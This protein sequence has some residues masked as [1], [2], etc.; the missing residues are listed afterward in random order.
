MHQVLRAHESWRLKGLKA[1][2]VL[3]NEHP[4]S[5]RNEMHEELAKIVETGPWGAWKNQP[6][7]IFVL[8]GEALGEA[9]RTLLLAAAKAILSGEK[10][11]LAQQLDQMEEEPP[12]PLETPFSDAPPARGAADETPEKI[13]VPPLLMDN[14]T[15]GFT[16]DGREYV[17]VL[18]G[19]KETPLPWSNILANPR[20][21][22]LVSASGTSYTWAENSRENRLTPF[23]ND[24]V[25]DATSE[26]L[27]LRDDETGAVFSATP[28]PL[29]RTGRSPRWVVRHTAGATRFT[30]AARGL[31]TEL[32]VFVAR[33]DPVKLSLLT[34]T[35]RSGRPRRLSLFSYAA[36]GLGP[37]RRGESYFVVTERTRQPDA[38]LARNPY[39]AEYA[40]HVAF[41]GASER[42]ASATGDRLEFF[43]RNGT[44]S[45]AAAFGSPKLKERF[46][47][48]LDPCAALQVS[49]D[50]APGETKRVVFSLGQGRD[51]GEAL[52]LAEKY[53]SASAAEE[54]L[55]A[56]T[57][58]WDETLGAVEVKTPDDSFDLL[59]N[60]WLLYQ[61]LAGRYWA[62]CGYYQASG[63]FGFRDQL[64]DS[65]A[66]L[67]VRP[68]LT[69]EHI[70]R[71]AARQFVEGDVQHW[72]HPP[73]GRGLRSRCSDDLLWLPYAVARYLDATGDTSIL[74]ERAPYLEAPPVPPGEKES[75]GLP[76]VSAESDTLLGHCLRAIDKGLTLGPHGL[77]LIGS[78]D[79]NDGYDR[80]GL[81]GRG[82]S[83]W[84]GFFLHIIL[85]DFA[86]LSASRGDHERAQRY[87]FERERLS[88][89]LEQAWDGAWYRRAYF[90]DGTPLGSAQNDEGRI[91]SLAQTWAILS[92]AAPPERAERAMDAVRAH[93][94]KRVSRVILL[95][96]PAF[97]K[98]ALEPG[99]IKGYVPG[100]RENGGQ[101]THA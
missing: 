57:V 95:L 69:R 50:L 29:R 63:A 25:T 27:F 54:E 41:A 60:R 58:S 2:A 101:Y 23:A 22:S 76:A 96:H 71:S 90:D 34:V 80:V 26:A 6:G 97:D 47:G 100:I 46:G 30:R 19:A 42:L 59:M 14:K 43:G 87:L 77:P 3:L 84:L 74:E 44:F 61:T 65:L 24:P 78:C 51:R 62:R 81:E 92:G 67:P 13:E 39:N 21:G 75:Y 73:S 72:W 15:G 16:K 88:G 38:V 33:E 98:T 32:C 49:L 20:F 79:W 5:Y 4:A 36:W 37:P 91:D 64:Q 17:V 40:G 35:N 66:F 53:G 56:V 70:L 55:S 18:D 31:L 8:R 45:R 48:G 93:L 1:D 82:E 94:V 89:M 52:A 9:E 85:S 83:V 28:G 12:L 10:G 11:E 68:R 86:G 99:Y 7:G